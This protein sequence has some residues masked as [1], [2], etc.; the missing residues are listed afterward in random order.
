MLRFI[1]KRLAFMALALVCV[2]LITFT[3]MQMAPGNFLDIQILSS[4]L[5]TDVVSSR[6]TI[7]RWEQR[8]GLDQPK[9]IQFFRFMKGMVTLDLGPS[10]QYPSLDVEEIIQKSFPV[11]LTL[12]VAS[13]LVALII[14]IPLGILAAVKQNSLWDYV[15]MFISM[16]GNAIPAYVLAVFL[17]LLFTLKLRVLPSGGWSEPKHMIMPVLALSLTSVAGIARYMRSSMVETLRADYIAAAWAKGG[18]FRNVV[19][20][21]ALRNSLIPL[22]TVVGPLLA[23]LMVGTVF[24]ESMFRIPGLGQYFAQAAAN[25][26]F[27]VLMTATVFFAF[28]I[29]TMNLIV[30]LLYGLLDP[31]IRYE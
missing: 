22:I 20:N 16:V 10:F 11:S 4:S 17:M 19:L 27:P 13:V 15:A 3:L 30:D 7:G 31:R 29:M 9:H 23:R 8:Y 28:V 14:A 24:I 6:E 18:S 21:H 2:A 1:A 5:Q 25:R 12:A 26:D